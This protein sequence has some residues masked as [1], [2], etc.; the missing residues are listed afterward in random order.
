MK[1]MEFAFD[2]R[3]QGDYLPHHYPLAS[4]CY[5]GTHDNPPLAQWLKE[6]LPQDLE[7]ARAYLN[8]SEEEGLVWGMIRGCLSSISQ[9]AI[10]QMQDYLELGGEARMNTPGTLSCHNWT[11]RAAPDAFTRELAEKIRTVTKQ[12]GR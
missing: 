8:L 4:V 1:V 2:S 9:L 10:I 6:A 12:H 11:W 5:S 3:E 7:A